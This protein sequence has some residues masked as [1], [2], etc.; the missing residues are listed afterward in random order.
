[1][2]VV[3][4]FLLSIPLPTSPQVP[5][6][7]RNRL[8]PKSN[9]KPPVMSIL[10]NPSPFGK[11]CLSA[12]QIT[13]SNIYVIDMV[14][15]SGRGLTSLPSTPQP[16]NSLPYRTPA[17]KSSL[18]DIN[19]TPY[20]KSF[21]SNQKSTRIMNSNDSRI[22]SRSD[23]TPVAKYHFDDSSEPITFSHY[24]DNSYSKS[25]RNNQLFENHNQIIDSNPELK[26]WIILLGTTKPTTSGR[27]GN[28]DTLNDNV[29]AILKCMG[30]YGEVVEYRVCDGNWMFIK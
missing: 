5:T 16:F 29:K 9:S 13:Y 18:A 11:I 8:H 12:I 14:S 30:G 15:S 7:I 17:A 24:D 19:D 22:F 4:V 28:S 23:E 21:Q 6:G 10:E 20:L 2:V 1:M 3:I 27:N 25:S 26:N